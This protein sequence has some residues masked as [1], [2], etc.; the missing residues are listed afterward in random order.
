[1]S[2]GLFSANS[3]VQKIIDAGTQAYGVYAFGTS[4]SS[5]P[6]N[7]GGANAHDGRYGWVHRVPKARFAGMSGLSFYVEF[8]TDQPWCCRVGDALSGA[9]VTFLAARA[10][11]KWLA[12]GPMQSCPLDGSGYGLILNNAAGGVI[13]DS[14][15]RPVEIRDYISFDV[16][17][18]V[19]NIGGITVRPENVISS[20]VSV[21]ADCGFIQLG[22]RGYFENFDNGDVYA[23]WW[24]RT[25]ATAA[26]F[27]AVTVD[28]WLGYPYIAPVSNWSGAGM[29]GALT[30]RTVSG[31]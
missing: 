8:T 29:G 1:M 24:V 14:R 7:S 16:S 19:S 18:Y 10:S 5:E 15:R 2:Y 30:L 28:P 6:A 4:T 25:G 22:Y 13:Y 23:F 12:I 21:S 17:R 20:P 11:V 26:Q 27:K 31:F 3:G 9:N